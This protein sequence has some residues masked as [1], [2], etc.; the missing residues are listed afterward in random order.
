VHDKIQRIRL[1]IQEKNCF[2]DLFNQTID[3]VVAVFG[4]H[5]FRAYFDAKWEKQINRPL[6]DAVTLVFSRLS[7]PDLVSR[8]TQIEE[9]LKELF[10]NPDFIQATSGSKAH[11]SNFVTRIKMF[12]LALA[13]ISLDSGLH[14]EL[15]E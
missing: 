15:S 11:R 6:F 2:I 10:S 4:N 13:D 1:D 8:A 5:A 3:K 14:I 12:S 7:Q 9:K